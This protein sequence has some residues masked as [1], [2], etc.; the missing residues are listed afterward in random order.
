M[1]AHIAL[2]AFV[3]VAWCQ[4]TNPAITFVDD[5]LD[6]FE[7]LTCADFTGTEVDMTMPPCTFNFPAM[8]MTAQCSAA[9]I[10]AGCGVFVGDGA[11][12]TT[13]EGF[14]W[15]SQTAGDNAGVFNLDNAMGATPASFNLALPRLAGNTDFD[16]DANLDTFVG[17]VQG[18][19][20]LQR[21]I[22]GVINS[23][24]NYKFKLRFCT[25][26]TMTSGAVS[27]DVVVNDPTSAV[28]FGA[29]TDYSTLVDFLP[30]APFATAVGDGYTLAS[31][32]LPDSTMAP[33]P[34]AS[35]CGELEIT[36]RHYEL[37]DH[38]TTNGFA[39]RVSST[40]VVGG[41][42]FF[43][44][45]VELD[46][47]SNLEGTAAVSDPV[48]ACNGVFI[49]EIDYLVDGEPQPGDMSTQ[50]FELVAPV[51][52]DLQGYRVRG[53][54][55][56]VELFNVEIDQSF[57]VVAGM[58]TN[59]DTFGHQVFRVSEGLPDI[60]QGTDAHT[61]QLL[62]PTGQLLDSVCYGPDSAAI[63]TGVSCTHV[64]N[65]DDTEL[66]DMAMG[67]FSL[68]RYGCGG[69]PGDFDWHVMASTHGATA[70]GPNAMSAGMENA[71]MFVCFDDGDG[72]WPGQDFFA[73]AGA[74][75]ALD[76]YA[77]CVCGGNDCQ[78]T[79]GS[80]F[81]GAEEQCDGYLTN[82]TAIVDFQVGM[83]PT[84]TEVLDARAA[85]RTGLPF[86]NLGMGG[87]TQSDEGDHDGD[88]RIDCDN[89]CRDGLGPALDTDG[90]TSYGAAAFVCDNVFYPAGAPATC[91]AAAEVCDGVDNDC[92]GE[93][94]APLV[95][96]CPDE[97]GD[98]YGQC[99]FDTMGN[100][101][102]LLA[103]NCTAFD[104]LGNLL[105]P[106]GYAPTNDGKRFY[107][108]F[109]FFANDSF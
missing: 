32:P 24:T 4:V 54:V 49:S 69:C 5:F 79:V 21:V 83:M 9:I 37:F 103:P 2:L 31:E 71:N 60:L 108:F 14:E 23:R 109:L 95:L 48:D 47:F 22:P 19:D 84:D 94:F 57:I 30:V 44:V 29:L 105:F 76:G 78:A 92:D 42:V 58:G 73:S 98:F 68:Q 3:A 97:D 93:F 106:I 86:S 15:T 100:H 39:V 36:F 10:P 101:D 38:V 41:P 91:T 102:G 53:L 46:E 89:D 63:P 87:V 43:E 17:F 18:T 80:V 6:G 96:H 20:S 40:N 33:M 12:T 70:P 90:A 8:M 65:L 25:S 7:D 55:A 67:D 81:P 61:I 11:P 75:T 104:G 52:T 27:L 34:P 72:Y 56:G 88:G 35:A 77:G 13:F 59:S 51:G 62:S 45:D 99:N 66:E 28:A 50:V 85:T 82:C 64:L 1:I 74:I 16:V 26:A 107:F